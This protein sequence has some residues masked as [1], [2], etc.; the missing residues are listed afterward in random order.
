MQRM[1]DNLSSWQRKYN[2][3]LE[4]MER[5]KMI[6]TQSILTIE[7]ERKEKDKSSNVNQLEDYQ[8]RILELMSENENLAKKYK[9]LEPLVSE[10]GLLEARVKDQELR[11]QLLEQECLRWRDQYQDSERKCSQGEQRI[12]S[13]ELRIRDQQDW[14][15]K[16]EEQTTIL[17]QRQ[18]EVEN[19][20]NKDRD[21]A[22]LREL[23]QTNEEKIRTLIEEND[24]VK[25]TLAEKDRLLEDLRIK[26]L[27]E[28]QM[29]RIKIEEFKSNEDFR[30][31]SVMVSV[32]DFRD[33]IL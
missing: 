10:K 19:L 14:R 11:L 24:R 25:R 8:R 4:E 26:L 5:E 28:E 2:E 13:L 6:M 7:R 23:L 27:N 30:R 31:K 18:R 16:Y 32:V 17:I 33:K 9:Q 12:Q 29:F 22:F 20:K 15:V 1:T 3:L 21:E